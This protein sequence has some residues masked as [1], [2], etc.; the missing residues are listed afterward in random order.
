MQEM[1]IRYYIFFTDSIIWAVQTSIADKSH[2]WMSERSDATGWRVCHKPGAMSSRPYN[3][4]NLLWSD[5]VQSQCS[6]GSETALSPS[7]WQFTTANH[8]LS[9]LSSLS[10]NV[11][12]TDRDDYVRIKCWVSVHE[13]AWFIMCC[14]CSSHTHFPLVILIC[15]P[16]ETN[17]STTALSSR[18]QP[19]LLFTT[20]I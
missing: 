3:H 2:P 1:S 14:S 15:P 16:D 19:S 18:Y 8:L 10:I 20:D 9:R 7:H 11:K 4:I 13:S 5:C 12:Q 6:D 17:S